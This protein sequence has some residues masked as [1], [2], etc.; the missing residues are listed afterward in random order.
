MDLVRLACENKGGF[1][2][3]VAHMFKPLCPLVYIKKT[4]KNLIGQISYII[5]LFVLLIFS[6]AVFSYFLHH[7]FSELIIIWQKD[8][9]NF[10]I[11][12]G[13]IEK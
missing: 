3:S 13:F 2:E 12:C 7:V 11:F 1:F 9:N 10:R 5:L 8:F 4:G 6:V